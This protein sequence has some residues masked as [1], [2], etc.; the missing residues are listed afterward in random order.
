[1]IARNRN[2]IRTRGLFDAVAVQ[3]RL[4]IATDLFVYA[5][6]RLDVLV[7]TSLK[8]I[9]PADAGVLILVDPLLLALFDDPVAVAADPGARFSFDAHVD[10]KSTRLNSSHANISYAVFC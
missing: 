2:V 8:H 5:A 4:M 6:I 3:G 7:A 1:M 9:V 10:R